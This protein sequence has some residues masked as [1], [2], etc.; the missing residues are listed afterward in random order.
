MLT[1]DYSGIWP[2]SPKNWFSQIK[3]M[4]ISFAKQI[5]IS[6]NDNLLFEEICKKEEE[7]F[8]GLEIIKESKDN[9]IT[10]LG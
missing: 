7:K 8:T 1:F 4:N 10:F 3:K 9:T 6:Q 2:T 5:I